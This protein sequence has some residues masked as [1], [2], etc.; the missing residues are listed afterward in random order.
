MGLV[1]SLGV[2]EALP[3]GV[4]VLLNSRVRV[5]SEVVGMG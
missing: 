4:H 2:E 5:I 3:G 1:A